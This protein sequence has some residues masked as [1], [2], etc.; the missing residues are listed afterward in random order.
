[1]MRRLKDAALSLLHG[2]FAALAVEINP[3]TGTAPL[4]VVAPHADD[5]TLGCAAVMQRAV[6]AGRRVRVVIVSDGS[7]SVVSAAISP[8]R[9]AALREDEAVAAVGAFGLGREDVEFLGFPDSRLGDAQAAIAEAL[10]ARIVALAPAEIYVPYGI[11]GH[12]DH[13]AVAAAVELLLGGGKVACPVYEYPVWF[14]PWKAL[15]HLAMPH[16]LL[17]LRRVSTAGCLESKRQAMLSYRSQ[18][19]NFT[20]EPGA[21]FLEHRMLANFFKRNELF[22]EKR[23]AP[24]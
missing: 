18:M 2:L 22:F 20:G 11:D 19:E 24:P 4:L 16:R 12:R 9:L 5:E 10:L 1:M 8:Q 14:W 21:W 17:R 7:R 23:A 13:R 3:E 15:R 6:R